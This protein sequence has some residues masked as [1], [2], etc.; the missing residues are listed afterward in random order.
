MQSDLTPFSDSETAKMCMWTKT[1]CH[2]YYPN[3][4]YMTYN[5]FSVKSILFVKTPF[6]K[7]KKKKENLEGFLTQQLAWI[8]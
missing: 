7:K 8:Q 5:I 6:F 1:V 3:T 2:I 4:F